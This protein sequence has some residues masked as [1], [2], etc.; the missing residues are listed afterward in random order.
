MYIICIVGAHIYGLTCI[1]FY[2]APTKAQS[3]KY[4][5][6]KKIV[7]SIVLVSSENIIFNQFVFNYFVIII[8]KLVMY[9]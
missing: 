3:V 4:D 8:F 6:L 9:L 2:R 5:T 1:P 7:A